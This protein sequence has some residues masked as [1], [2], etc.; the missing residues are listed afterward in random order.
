MKKTSKVVSKMKI[1]KKTTAVKKS[2][3]T[4]TQPK[5][6]DPV[7][8][9]LKVAIFPNGEGFYSKELTEVELIDEGLERYVRITQE[10]NGFIEINFNEWPAICSAFEAISEGVGKLFEL[11]GKLPPEAKMLFNGKEQ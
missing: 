3:K 8:A 4:K 1:M 10:G 7:N 5:Y 6:G 11:N 2:M 9:V